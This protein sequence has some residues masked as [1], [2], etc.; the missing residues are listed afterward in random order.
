M[1]KLGDR[2]AQVGEQKLGKGTSVAATPP[3]LKEIVDGENSP[4]LTA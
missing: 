4:E 1:V 3:H 2:Y